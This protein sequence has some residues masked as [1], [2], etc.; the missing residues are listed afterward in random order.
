[1]RVRVST[2]VNRVGDGERPALV[3]A[4]HVLADVFD[5]ERLLYDRRLVGIGYEGELLLL[6]RE[7]VA[8]SLRLHQTSHAQHAQLR[9][10]IAS[11]TSF[12]LFISFFLYLFIASAT[13]YTLYYTY[14]YLGQWD[15]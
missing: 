1:M 14:E 11:C 2:G 5:V 15:A 6:A 13:C 9:C 4:V 10:S 8:R 3:V 7:L 12:Y